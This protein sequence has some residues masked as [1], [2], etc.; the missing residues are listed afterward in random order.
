MLTAVQTP[1]ARSGVLQST[2][3]LWRATEKG[4]LCWCL[5]ISKGEEE[6][7]KIK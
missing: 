4:S 5:Q 2:K 7:N 1:D 6:A 3:I